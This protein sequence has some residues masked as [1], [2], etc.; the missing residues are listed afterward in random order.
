MSHWFSCEIEEIVRPRG[1]LKPSVRRVDRGFSR[2]EGN[3]SRGFVIEGSSEPFD[4]TLRSHASEIERPPAP[5]LDTIPADVGVRVLTRATVVSTVGPLLRSSLQVITL[6]TGG[7]SIVATPESLTIDLGYLREFGGRP[8]KERADPGSLP[9]AWQNGSAAV[10]FHESIGH[11]AERGRFPAGIPSWLE[12]DDAPS[13]GD[14]VSFEFDDTGAPIALKTLTDRTKPSALRRW[15]HRDGP[16]R[17]M[18]NLLA[19]GSGSRMAELPK[20]RIDVLLVAAGYWDPQTDM[21]GVHVAAA[22]LVDGPH[23]LPIEPFDYTARREE[24]FPLLAGWF[25]EITRHPGVM[26]GDEGVSMPVGSAA[27]G[28][29]TEAR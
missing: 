24:L 17:R 21:L 16:T 2:V 9:I 18:T 1:T 11:P 25:G 22:D 23:R 19:R 13:S 12:I 7:I 14:L 20:T 10:L 28:V 27:V 29:L 6:S 15:S 5:L 8:T 26:C 3:E 4:D